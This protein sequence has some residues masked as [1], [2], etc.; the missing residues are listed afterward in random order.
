MHEAHSKFPESAHVQT[1][2][3]PTTRCLRQKQGKTIQDHAKA[4]DMRQRAESGGQRACMRHRASSQSTAHV[5]TLHKRA[6]TNAPIMPQAPTRCLGQKDGKTL[7][8]HTRQVT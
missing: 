2:T 8:D 5:Y 1:M 3:Q 7:Q 4:S 6:T